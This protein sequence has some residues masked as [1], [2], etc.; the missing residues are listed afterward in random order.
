MSPPRTD[1][2]LIGKGI[3]GLGR[4]LSMAKD[5][6]T[7]P[8]NMGSLAED[9]RAGM[10]ARAG[11]V[12]FELFHHNRGG[13]YSASQLFDLASFVLV[14]L[15]LLSIVPD[16]TLTKQTSW[17]KGEV[18]SGQTWKFPDPQAAS[19]FTEVTAVKFG[20]SSV[21]FLDKDDAVVRYAEWSDL[22]N[23]PTYNCGTECA[24]C[25]AVGKDVRVSVIVS[26]CL[27]CVAMLFSQ[28]RKSKETDSHHYKFICSGLAG[29]ASL[30]SIV[31]LIQ[32]R[33]KCGDDLPTDGTQFS[34]AGATGAVTLKYSL[35]TGYLGVLLNVLFSL[36]TLFIHILTPSPACF[37]DDQYEE[38]ELP[39][40]PK[41]VDEDD[42]AL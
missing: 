28:K 7:N 38:K 41:V 39:D 8:E 23:N 14:F 26:V 40:L 16:Q 24:N 21:V 35:S 11:S 18:K 4:S 13:L 10:W 20:L 3:G 29:L 36:L 5:L 32:F 31:S 22:P 1:S 30:F 19:N 15:A 34:V 12:G 25:S 37:D 6:A 9:L 42:V 17:I 33:S 2:S 27:L